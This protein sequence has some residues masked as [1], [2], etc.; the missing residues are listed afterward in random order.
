M[1][2]VQHMPEEFTAAFAERL[3][4]ACSMEVKEAADGDPVARGRALVAPGNRHTMLVRN[5]FGFRVEVSDGPLVCRHRPSVDVLFRSVAQSA[6]VSSV[7]VLLTGMGDDGAAGLLEMRQ[8]GA[9]TVVQDE[10]S[11]IV[12]GMPK[13]A[14][15]RNAVDEVV[16]LSRMAEAI[17]RKVQPIHNERASAGEG[18][19]E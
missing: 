6:G 11:S 15:A 12:F 9:P 7:G 1:V 16:P 2:I 19:D 17:L 8:A 3:N 14:I 4:G 13:E 5:G 10:A 18:S